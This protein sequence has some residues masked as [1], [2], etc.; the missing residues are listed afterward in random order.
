MTGWDRRIDPSQRI[1][2]Q[3]QTR[4]TQG[5]GRL[6]NRQRGQI[7]YVDLTKT[8]PHLQ[9]DDGEQ[10]EGGARGGSEQTDYA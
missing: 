2:A 10:G 1:N 5:G 4:V 8:Q 9:P 3:S 6:V 7:R